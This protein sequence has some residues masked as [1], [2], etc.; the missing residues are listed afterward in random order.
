MRLLLHTY[1]SSSAHTRF[2]KD[3]YPYMG[4]KCT[5]DFSQKHRD[6][7]LPSQRPGFVPSGIVSSDPGIISS[8]STPI[9]IGPDKAKS[10]YA[11]NS[12]GL[13]IVSSTHATNFIG[14]GTVSS[15]HA[16]NFIGYG[17]VSSTHATNSIGYGTVSSTRTTNSIVMYVR[18]M[19][20]GVIFITAHPIPLAKISLP[21]G[22]SPNTAS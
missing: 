9:I 10:T 21:E 18:S 16:T 3:F 19:Y 2:G 11:T 17:I 6:A 15:T 8:C 7:V 20:S 1:P 12:I 5:F 22:K 4:E 13:G 14:Y